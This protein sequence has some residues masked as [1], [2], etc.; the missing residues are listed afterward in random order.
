MT[1]A[2]KA[3]ETRRLR[4][5]LPEPYKVANL[6]VS[7][8]RDGPREGSFMK[9]PSDSATI[10]AATQPDDGREHFR[11]AMLDV[12]RRVLGII[13]ISIGCATSSLVH[14]RELFR[15]ACLCGAVAIVVTHNHPSGD[16]EPSPED[17]ALTRR[18]AQAGALMGIEVV[19][20]VITGNGTDRT[21]SLHQR[22]V[23]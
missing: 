17:M 12:R 11:A 21:V 14:P 3:A 18:L 1:P 4:A 5:T 6:T 7:I 23:L 15:A 19:D 22:G 8:V 9:T 13:T 2:A 10:F 20:H 16:P